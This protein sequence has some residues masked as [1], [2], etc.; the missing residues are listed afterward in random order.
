[1][2]DEGRDGTVDPLDTDPRGTLASP[3]LAIVPDA[4][5]RM[6]GTV[7]RNGIVLAL[8]VLL[9]LGASG[10]A[11]ARRPIREFSPLPSRIVLD[12]VCQTFSIVA[13]FLVNRVYVTTFTDENGDPVRSH[14]TGSLK[15]RLTNPENGASVVRNLSGPG[16]TT[17]HA[18]GSR[19]IV[20]RGP[21]P[22]FYFPGELF[23]GSEGSF[24][25]HRGRVVL[26]IAA[27]GTQTIVSESGTSEDLCA[28]LS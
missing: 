14:T 20:A 23:P 11:S 27:D 5:G 8:G 2:R 25:V 16:T 6:E 22:F 18:D 3:L 21:W 24:M 17:Y 10:S 9:V 7:R 13:D 28:T 4:V 26:E 15:V 1:M 19:T 12:D